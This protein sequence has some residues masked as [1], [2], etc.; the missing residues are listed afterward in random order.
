M[1]KFII[2]LFIGFSAILQAQNTLSGIVTDAKKQPLIGVSIYAPELHKG[3]STDENGKYLLSN[4][5]N[6]KIK[7]TFVYVGFT[8]QNKTLTLEKKETILDIALDQTEFQIDEVIVST[9]FNKIQSQNVMKVEH[10]SIKELQQN[11]TSTLIEGLATIPG[12]SQVSTGTS[13]G[14]PVI[15]GLSGN[16]VLVYSQ[17]VRIENQQFGDEHGL[18]LND[19]GIESVEVI[20]GPASLLY[21]SDALGGVLYLNPEKFANSGTFKTNFSQK[22]FSNTLGS[23]S[24]LGLKTST[25]N[26]K[27]LARGSY[28]THSDYKIADGNRVTNT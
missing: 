3:T 9:A 23:N 20:K 18:G 11:G 22:F 5:P 1:K 14:K 6:G 2:A 16:R 25:E 8:T 27:F 4:L 24:T 26:W 10:S 13:I 15:R 19:A 28:N 21:G 17:G 7:V 12:V